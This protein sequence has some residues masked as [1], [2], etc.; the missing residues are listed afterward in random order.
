VKFLDT[1]KT[2]D[3]CAIV[4]QISRKGKQLKSSNADFRRRLLLCTVV[5][6]L[7]RTHATRTCGG[8]CDRELDKPITTSPG[9]GESTSCASSLPESQKEAPFGAED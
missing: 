3:I 1:L 2:F 6:M 7:P 9:H 8:D 5:T 4:R